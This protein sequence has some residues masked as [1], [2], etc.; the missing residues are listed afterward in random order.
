[1][2]LE[3]ESPDFLVNCYQ[4]ARAI[5]REQCRCRQCGIHCSP[6]C[7][8]CEICGTQD[9]VRLPF[10]WLSFVTAAV[11]VLAVTVTWML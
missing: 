4:S 9:P 10:V 5:A 11:V 6:F 2:Q 1:M 8:M 7:S 3:D